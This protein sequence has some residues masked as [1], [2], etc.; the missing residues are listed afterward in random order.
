V[1]RPHLDVCPVH[2]R[3]VNGLCDVGGGEHHDIGEA[4]QLVQLSQQGVHGTNGIRG[5]TTTCSSLQRGREGRREGR[6]MS[7]TDMHTHTHI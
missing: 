2:K 3:Q 6:Q 4:P 7:V 5:L 1:L